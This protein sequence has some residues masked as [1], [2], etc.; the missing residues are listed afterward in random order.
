MI[1]T[2]SITTFFDPYGDGKSERKVFSRKFYHTEKSE[3]DIKAIFPDNGKYYGE[4][5]LI[6]KSYKKTTLFVL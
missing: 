3:A 2:F 6:F 5:R 4:I 1:T